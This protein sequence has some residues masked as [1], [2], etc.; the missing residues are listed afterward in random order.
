MSEEQRT[1]WIVGATF[2]ALLA[3]SAA[4]M[5]AFNHSVHVADAFTRKD[6][7]E[8]VDRYLEGR[9]RTV[10]I[11]Q[12]GQLVWDET[13]R[14]AVA[15]TDT[16]WMDRELG[17]FP[18]TNQGAQETMLVE[19]DGTLVR[20]WR[21]GHYDPAYPYG[22]LRWQVEAALDLARSNRR[23]SGAMAR[24]E[25]RGGTLWPVDRRGAPLTRWASSLIW[26]G[27]RPMLLT[28]AAIVPDRD[29]A[30]LKAEPRYLVS[31]RV[32]DSQVLRALG[33]DLLLPDFRFVSRAPRDPA[34]NI[35]ARKSADGRPVGYFVWTAQLPGPA[36]WQAAAPL[37]A[38]WIFLFLAVLAGGVMIVRRMRDT[39][40]HL[41]ASEAQAQYNALHDP[42]SGLANRLYFAER[43]RGELDIVI[44]QRAQG[45]QGDVFVAYIDLDAFKT[46]NDTMGHHVGD[47]LVTQVAQRLRDGLLRTDLIARFGGDEF[48]VM[49]RTT[50]GLG[51]ANALGRQ[52][53]GLMAEPFIISGHSL[54]VTCSCGISWGPGQTEDADELLRRADISLYRAK[55]G[56]RARY[57]CYTNG[58]E[59]TERLARE[60]EL[61]LRRAIAAD[62]LEAHFQPIVDLST[63]QIEGFE[64]LLRWP[65]PQ[66]GDIG[67]GVFV[68]IAEQCGLMVPLGTWMLRRVFTQCRNWPACD[69]SINLSPIQIMAHGFVETI[70]SLVE[71]T[72][73]SPR[74]VILEVTEGVMLDRSDNVAQSLRTLQ[75]MGFRIAL[76]DFG[77]GYS[78]LSYL[79]SFQFDRIKID[80]SFVQNIEA[81]HD[82]QSIL[83]AIVALGQ[84]L[85][86]KVVAE[87]VE[88]ELQ[89][90][91]VHAAGCELVQ[92]HLF[93]PAL[94]ADQACAL[95]TR[96]AADRMRQVI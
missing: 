15:R 10:I 52:V 11:G 78:S 60:L 8:M 6:E 75:G 19:P 13:M 71:E 14:H 68:P 42:M 35:L 89:R 28:V 61:E 37:L 22:P 74:R 44:A 17:M 36:I 73:I 26:R 24:F 4:L 93:W 12:T 54:G 85:R 65:H 27:G 45:G 30:L 64:A 67:P 40:R 43:L 57:R 62:E 1:G 39:T 34:L 76:D 9:V 92:G 18:W 91:L 55:Q 79:R 63:W 80:R 31:L 41:Q 84:T 7:R 81:D 21:Q 95:L 50:G 82:A 46:V 47:E 58:M 2:A 83:G 94:P 49:R 70:Q 29:Y 66:R 3:L 96:N 33:A 86:M 16:N 51:A 77:I 87:G 48:V 5:A 20:G 72:G 25:R 56:G 23:I 88:T 69:L 59:A 32:M 53:V 38:T 90:R